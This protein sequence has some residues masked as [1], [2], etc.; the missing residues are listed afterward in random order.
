MDVTSSREP[1]SLSSIR[2]RFLDGIRG[3]AA[4]Y[5]L[6]FHAFTNA[7]AGA[8]PTALDDR[9]NGLL[10]HGQAAVVVFIVLSGF[11]LMIPVARSADGQFKGGYSGFFLRRSLRILPPYYA[12]LF[13][14]LLFI[15]LMTQIQRHLSIGYRDFTPSLSAKNILSH[16]FLVHDL[17]FDTAFTINGAA[18]TVAT[19][20]QIYFVFALL[21]LPLWRR[22]GN[23]VP[24]LI[25]FVL[26]LI[27]GFF[28]PP[29]SNFYWARPWYLGLFALGMAAAA[30]QFSDRYAANP[31]R[32]RFPWGVATLVL[33][34]VLAA[35]QAFH[36]LAPYWYMDTL[37]GLGA[38]AL[39][40]YCTVHKLHPSAAVPRPLRFLESRPV[41]ALG[42]FS[43]T[44]YLFQNIVQKGTLAL[45]WKLHATPELRMAISVVI[46]IPAALIISYLLA[47][48]TERPF[49]TGAIARSLKERKAPTLD[50]TLQPRGL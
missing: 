48:V 11:S 13:A 41:A 32:R 14:S 44:L 38:V 3:L 35:L 37:I 26:G 30:L 47:Q 22:F 6:I 18:W 7:P 10:V 29:L 28:L 1:G 21:L 15:V 42:T 25:A 20:W 5:V 49:V 39:I 4:L 12:S 2:F 31:L 27:P 40:C 50:G 8:P 45:A 23:A 43:Y 24:L 46:G 36:K 9:V 33:A 34:L 16:L 19:E 17:W